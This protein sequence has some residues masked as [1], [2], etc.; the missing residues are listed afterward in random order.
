[1]DNLDRAENAAAIS[2]TIHVYGGEDREIT[3]SGSREAAG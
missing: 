1:M 3:R 2:S